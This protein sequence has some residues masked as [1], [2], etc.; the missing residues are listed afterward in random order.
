MN[1]HDPGHRKEM[2]S[3]HQACTIFKEMMVLTIT[4]FITGLKVSSYST[5]TV[6]QTHESP[7]E[8]QTCQLFHLT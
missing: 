3:S 7:G 4:I 8:L 2:H 5:H 1:T 6:E